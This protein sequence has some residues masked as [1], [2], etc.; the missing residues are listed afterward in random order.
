MGQVHKIGSRAASGDL[1]EVIKSV[2][3]S[4]VGPD[5]RFELRVDVEP[6]V[7]PSHK[8]A[9]VAL[10]VNELVTN[11]IKHGFRERGTGVV[12]VDLHRANG[13]SVLLTVTDD[14]VPLPGR[15]EQ[16]IWNRAS[17]G[18][19][20]ANQLAG[21]LNVDTEPKRFSIVFPADT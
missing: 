21:V 13:N 2:C 8:A 9:V 19:R 6:L 3:T 12:A 16:F 17:I 15:P 5:P 11:A 7:V 18:D 14:G 10:I 4:I 1:D 20:L